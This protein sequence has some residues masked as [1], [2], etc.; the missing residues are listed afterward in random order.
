MDHDNQKMIETF[1]NA[2]QTKPL[3]QKELLSSQTV[4]DTIRA[5]E[6][7]ENF[8]LDL[9]CHMVLAKRSPV[10]A[11]VGMLH[12]HFQ[13]NFQ[14][15]QATA[16]ALEKAI[17]AQLVLWDPEKEQ[18][19]IRFEVSSTVHTLIN[20]YQY[21]PPMIVPPRKISRVPGYNR[22]SGY[23]TVHTD[24]LILK[25]NHH[26][27][28]L[29]VDNLDNY[30]QVPLQLNI[31]VAT[32]INNTWKN[33]DKPREDETYEEY[34][35]RDKAFDK[36]QKDTAFTMALLVEMGNRFYVTHKY[37]KRGRTYAQGYHINPQGNCWNKSCIELA[38]EELINQ[39]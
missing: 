14:P 8:V 31:K 26:D 24:S 1:F 28:E 34:M 21:L 29:C 5:S 22:G 3:I 37:D 15:M 38:D 17:Q 23:L 20:Q 4:I 30:N 19:V 7:D 35:K 2:R 11:L 12:H 13:S 6:L 25:N 39:E 27:G 18:V 16:D 10:N 9:L 32:L 36:Y 33:L